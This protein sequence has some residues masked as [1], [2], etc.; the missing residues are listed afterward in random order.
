MLNN[1]FVWDDVDVSYLHGDVKKKP[2]DVITDVRIHTA[3]KLMSGLND[4]DK[5]YVLGLIRGFVRH[6]KAKGK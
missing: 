6:N 2:T 3:V 1:K 4:A 5:Q